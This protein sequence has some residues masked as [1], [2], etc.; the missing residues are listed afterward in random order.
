MGKSQGQKSR[1]AKRGK[2]EPFIYCL[3]TSTIRGQKLPLTEEIDLA[4]KAG[5]SA[6]EPWIS[7]IEE[8]V[9]A[10]GTTKEL[11]K[12]IKDHG[13]TVESAIG[14][15]EWIVDDNDRRAKGIEQAKRDLDLISQIGAKRIAAPAAGAADVSNIDLMKAAERYLALQNLADQFGIISQVEVWGFSKTLTT[16]SA[17]A[18]VAIQ[19]GHPKAC[20]LADI[21]H[22]YKG[23]SDFNG[24][25]LLSSDALEVIHMNDYPDKPTRARINDSHR[26]YPGDGI[27]PMD[28][29]LHILRD[30]GYTG[31][32]SV[33]LFNPNYYKQDAYT[34]IKT[35]LDKTRTV[36][37][38]AM[39]TY[40]PPKS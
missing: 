14:F 7:E 1:V 36:V 21:Y 29:I 22:L 20:I 39:E 11:R 26:V 38:H 32:L 19:S 23:G 34:V 35:A 40:K 17:A 6:I 10:G 2:N 12:R 31:A 24:L 37:K 9:R 13:M 28:A 27:A 4:A 5:Y 15:A 33:E 3:N 8:H 25:K 16:L 18:F 30:I